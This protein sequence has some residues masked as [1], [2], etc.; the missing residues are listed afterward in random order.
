M[1]LTYSNVTR[2]TSN[3][4]GVETGLP[5]WGDTDDMEWV[6]STPI[7]DNLD[8]GAYFY[9]IAAALVKR[10][11]VRGD[12]LFGAPYDFRK[13]PSKTPT[14]ILSIGIYFLIQLNF[15]FPIDSNHR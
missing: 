1:R 5:K 12:T 11:Y 14:F 8:Y 3:T 10:G 7:I 13:G 2:E 9:Y 15:L 6:D 4:P